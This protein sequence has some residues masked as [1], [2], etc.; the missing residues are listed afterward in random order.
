LK[1]VE[2]KVEYPK[3]VEEDV[4]QHCIVWGPTGVGKTEFIKK[5]A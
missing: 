5:I 4:M 1:E 3:K 2:H